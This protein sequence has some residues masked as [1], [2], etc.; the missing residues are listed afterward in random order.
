METNKFPTFS[1]KKNMKFIVL[2]LYFILLWLILPISLGVFF[3]YLLYPIINFVHKRL[4]LPYIISAIVISILI[5]IGIYSFIYIFIQSII[6]IYPEAKE[7]LNNLQLFK[8]E[9]V[10]LMENIY[11]KSLSYID[12]AVMNVVGYMQD[13]FQ[14]IIE[15]FI[16][17]VAF[18]FSI[19]ESRRDR[20]W[21]FAYVPKGYRDEWK[22]YFSKAINLFSYFIYVEFQ[23]FIITFFLLSIGLAL[24]QFE[25]PISKSFLISFADALPF[26]GIGL[27]L[28]P[29]AIFF[30]FTG[31]KFLCFALIILYIFIQITRQLVESMLW[32]STFHLRTV[33]TFFISAASILIFGIYGILISPFLLLIAVK[34]KDHFSVQQ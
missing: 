12:S 34:L 20:Y 3:S 25:N 29:I 33:H 1:Y 26:F 11:N 17:I 18:F 23:L 9:Y 16:F 14:Y 13:F 10:I 5:F 31:E 2:I 6:S 27:F 15:L 28:I 32:A 7:Q 8:S 21:F 24:L 4:K 19:F 30:L 22:Q